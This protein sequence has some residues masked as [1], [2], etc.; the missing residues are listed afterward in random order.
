M[1]FLFSDENP[2]PRGS[3]ALTRDEFYEHA[4]VRFPLGGRTYV[5][6]RLAFGAVPRLRASL[7]T[8]VTDA[9]F[10]FSSR[11]QHKTHP[12]LSLLD[13]FPALRD[14]KT[15]TAADKPKLITEGRYPTVFTFP[16]TLFADANPAE[17]SPELPFDLQLVSSCMLPRGNGFSR[18]KHLAEPTDYTGRRAPYLQHQGPTFASRQGNE[19]QDEVNLRS[20]IFRRLRT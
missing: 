12:R 5:T 16:L 3:E 14:R 13:V 4:V 20:F 15:F 10:C 17:A 8:Y 7:G 2:F 6:C 9:H 11:Q 19:K 18:E 1:R